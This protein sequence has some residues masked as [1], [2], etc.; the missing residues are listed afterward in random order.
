MKDASFTPGQH[1]DDIPFNC[2]WSSPVNRYGDGVLVTF[3]FK[4]KEDAAP[5]NSAVT[6]SYNPD[7][8]MNQ[9]FENVNFAVQAG[10]VTVA[11]S[12]TAGAWEVQTPATCTES[13]TEIQIDQRTV[14]Q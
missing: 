9:D 11:C 10:G 3:I 5:G 2:L 7:N 12:H 8:V 13:G 4:I 14:N 6:L 1:L